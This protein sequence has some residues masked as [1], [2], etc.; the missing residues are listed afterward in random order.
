MEHV[1]YF[2][3][4]SS[5][6][7]QDD[8]QYVLL[9]EKLPMGQAQRKAA[10]L[11]VLRDAPDP[12]K[13]EG[14]GEVSEWLEVTEAYLR[15]VI[16]IHGESEFW[17]V[18]KDRYVQDWIDGTEVRDSYSADVIYKLDLLDGVPGFVEVR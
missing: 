8:G 9:V 17:G 1:T 4:A 14:P 13:I 12:D 15:A 16:D 10:L 5:I 18:P 11:H 3:Y 7:E 2:L 6:Q